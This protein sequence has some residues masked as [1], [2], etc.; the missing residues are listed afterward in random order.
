MMENLTVYQIWW[1]NL[2]SYTKQLFQRRHFPATNWEYLTDS[3]IESIY[4]KE[5]QNK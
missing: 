1:K 4:H 2:G 5:K 3:M